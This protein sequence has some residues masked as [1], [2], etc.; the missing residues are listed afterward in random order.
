[1]QLK[2]GFFLQ[3]SLLDNV[4]CII[5][6]Y[7]LIRHLEQLGV[8]VHAFSP[9]DR[10]K[11]VSEGLYIHRVPTLLPSLE[12]TK[13]IY[14]CVF[15]IA[16][17]E[18]LAP[19]FF[20]REKSL[21]QFAKWLSRNTLPLLI[22]EKLDL[23]Q[24]EQEIP[25][26]ALLMMKEELKIPVVTDLLDLWVE[27]EILA[28][29]VKVGDIAYNSLRR[30]TKELLAKSDLIL[31]GN[32]IV[33]RHV[34]ATYEVESNKLIISPNAGA[35]RQEKRIKRNK[36]LR[37]IYA[38][39]FERY[40]Y[41][42]LFIE[43]IP[44]IRKEI[45]G[46]EILIAGRGPDRN[47]LHRLAASIGEENSL[48]GSL[49]RKRIFRLFTVCDIGVIPTKK[50]YATPI[51]I[52]DYLSVGLPVVSIKGMWWSKI[53]EEN[54]VGATVEFNPKS[55]AKGVVSLLMDRNIDEYSKNARRLVTQKYNWH[56]VA[57]DL[58]RVYE[59]LV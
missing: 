57:K 20:F 25:A 26:M 28:N 40:E 22:K 59:K 1:M 37:V 6:P 47:R 58:I 27:E 15:K 32:N 14:R 30:F 36:K 21:K 13:N 44:Y 55:F 53:V 46:I 35:I 5:R 7:E 23:V 3:R 42:D 19:S 43:S 8:E 4:G 12:I 31:V 2:V 34:M 18:F 10:S 54:K 16:K 17:S 52:F 49:P 56:N 11:R 48:I 38:G 51:K 29:R 50:Y 39:T 9:I 24:G 33:K 41:V 45:P